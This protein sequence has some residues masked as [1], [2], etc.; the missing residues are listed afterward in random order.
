MLLFFDGEEAFVRW[1]PTDSIYGARSLAEKWDSTSYPQDNSPTDHLDRMVSFFLGVKL[2][3]ETREN[4][5]LRRII[6]G[7]KE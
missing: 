2:I 7:M 1:G 3:S 5:I 4:N 6:N